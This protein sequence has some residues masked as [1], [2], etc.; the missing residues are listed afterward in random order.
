MR[1]S[2]KT[3]LPLIL[4]VF[5]SFAFATAAQSI[6]SSISKTEEQQRFN[7]YGQWQGCVYNSKSQTVRSI[8]EHSMVE[9][10]GTMR[11]YAMAKTVSG[12]ADCVIGTADREALQQGRIRLT[13][14][15]LPEYAGE[16]AVEKA[17]LPY[18]GYSYDLGQKISLE[19]EYTD[20]EGKLVLERREYYVCGILKSFSANWNSAEN[21]P[22]SGLIA[23]TDP[24][25]FLSEPRNII[26]FSG[27]YYDRETIQELKPLLDKDE[28]LVFNL[29]AYPEFSMTP[30]DFFENGMANILIF[31]GCL[32]FVFYT[33]SAMLAGRKYELQTMSFL[34]ASKRQMRRLCFYDIFHIFIITVLPGCLTGTGVAWLLIKCRE[35]F[36]ENAV[37]FH[38]EPCDILFAAALVAAAVA[39][40]NF[41]PF[42]SLGGTYS[43][44][45]GRRREAVRI[46]RKTIRWNCAL[47]DLSLRKFRMNLGNAAA[48]NIIAAVLAITVLMIFF[49]NLER[50]SYVMRC[51]ETNDAA[52]IWSGLS[53]SAG[54]SDSEVELLRRSEGIGTVDALVQL[55]GS[56][57]IGWEGSEDSEY[58]R[59]LM[60]RGIGGFSHVI[61]GTESGSDSEYLS[62]ILR[63]QDE[64]MITVDE[65]NRGE[66]VIVL[67]DLEQG[68][69]D[70]YRSE[71]LEPQRFGKTLLK[72]DTLRLGETVF[73][74][75]ELGRIEVKIGGIIRNFEEERTNMRITFMH[76]GTVIMSKKSLDMVRGYSSLYN[77]VL[78]YSNEMKPNDSYMTDKL[79]SRV[80]GI[81]D[82]HFHNMREENEVLEQDFISYF[83]LSLLFLFVILL[84]G[85]VIVFNAVRIYFLH[86]KGEIRTLRSL[87][88]EWRQIKRLYLFSPFLIGAGSALGALLLCGGIYYIPDIIGFMTAREWEYTA[89]QAIRITFAVKNMYFPLPDFIAIFL[90]LLF[91]LPGIYLIQLSRYRDHI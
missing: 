81:G 86:E 82:V 42:L 24:L 68:R 48:Q 4:V 33:S 26:L 59:L 58:L 11:E 77:L 20:G 75:T 34:G 64:G 55:K 29:G 74:E 22:V 90:G 21:G 40:G 83:F 49:V 15:R 30:Y 56:G 88:A 6:Q 28:T 91:Y 23:V 27:K 80:L 47:R 63:E 10:L 52:Y 12:A 31:F 46:P 66:A 85:G 69:E 67:P 18:L 87:G 14:G 65:F 3:Y 36:L 60:S 78:A 35:L 50:Y 16:I 44:M 17:M 79:A 72:E 1:K 84:L 57:R 25:C 71:L 53:S 43:D 76:P 9:T 73:I 37:V 32:A 39:A 51:N 19:I 38:V 2:R 61:F 7:T 5:F 70:T 89:E 45:N 8:S 13:E 54:L 41:W 62:Y